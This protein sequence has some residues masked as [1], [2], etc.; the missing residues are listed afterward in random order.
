MVIMMDG[1][2][3]YGI[4]VLTAGHTGSNDKIA[5]T[6]VMVD[7]LSSVFE[8]RMSAASHASHK[9]NEERSYGSSEEQFYQKR[10]SQLLWRFEL[11]E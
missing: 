2:M 1:Q 6:V 7:D 8:S 4:A 3:L 10:I 9:I 5:N 11:P